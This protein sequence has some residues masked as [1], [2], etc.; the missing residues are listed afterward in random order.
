LAANN[1]GSV[2]FPG[3]NRRLTRRMHVEGKQMLSYQEGQQVRGLVL[4]PL[5]PIGPRF[6]LFSP[7]TT[8]T[9]SL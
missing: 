2:R 1:K 3:K 8:F 9:A 7:L 5:C 6:G 4:S